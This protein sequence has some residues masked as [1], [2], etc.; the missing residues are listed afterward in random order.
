MEW[1][2]IHVFTIHA[3]YWINWYP[4]DPNQLIPPC[5]LPPWQ[6]FISRCAQID[7]RL[8]RNK[9]LGEQVGGLSTSRG[10]TM[11]PSRCET[12]IDLTLIGNKTI[13]I[14]RTIAHMSTS[15]GATMCPSRCDFNWGWTVCAFWIV[16]F[17]TATRLS[18]GATMCPSR[19]GCVWGSKQCS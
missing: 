10:V 19:S 16:C 11:C 14:L 6:S 15:R 8:G 9:W 5:F 1:Q 12:L 7:G 17:N 13:W 3:G 18:R 4:I 2:K